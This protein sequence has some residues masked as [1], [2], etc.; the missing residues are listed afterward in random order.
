MSPD[1]STPTGQTIAFR[2]SVIC[3][4]PE[5]ST[6]TTGPSEAHG[7][8]ALKLGEAAHI[9]AARPGQARYNPAM[10]DA[11]RS[12]AENGIWLCASCHTLIDKNG[13]ADFPVALLQ[14]WKRKHEEFVRS[15]LLTHRSP[16]PVLRR[17][18]EEGQIAQDAV[19]ELEQHGALFVDH[20]IEVQS[21]VIAS[22]ERLRRELV[23]LSRGIRYDS[24][25]KHIIKDIADECRSFMN[26]TSRFTHTAPSELE[27]LRSRIGIKVLQ[28]REDHGCKIRGP[29]NRI[30]PS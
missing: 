18:T 14:E 30:I 28:L 22:L 1:F 20:N 26:N 6:L 7:D 12:A 8:L 5:C 11:E 25:L 10:T 23:Q 3:S 4:N 24:Q 29:L 2:A 13:G 15:L 21:D 17:F 9:S 16:L 27:A 19:D